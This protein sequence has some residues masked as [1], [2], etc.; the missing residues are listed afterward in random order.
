[1]SSPLFDF[2]GMVISMKEQVHGING[3]AEPIILRSEWDAIDQ[4]EIVSIDK[5]VQDE[6]QEEVKFRKKSKMKLEV[7]D[8]GTP[9]EGFLI[10]FDVVANH[11]GWDDVDRFSYLKVALRGEAEKALSRDGP[12][13]VQELVRVLKR[14]YGDN[15]P[16]WYHRFA[17][18]A[19]RRGD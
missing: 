6:I 8:G 1:M 14:D 19:C 11:N 7:F 17:L 18:E 15:Q 4:S 16:V 9:L 2:D 3:M 5:P 12:Q 13:T 10:K